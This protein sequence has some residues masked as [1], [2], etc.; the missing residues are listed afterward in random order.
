MNVLI[1]RVATRMSDSTNMLTLSAKMCLE[2]IP[3][4]TSSSRKDLIRILR[5][6]LES[7]YSD[8]ACGSFGVVE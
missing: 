8:H 4:S 6:L 5:A 3:S 1:H 7:R 2:E